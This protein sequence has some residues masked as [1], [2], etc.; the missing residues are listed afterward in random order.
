MIE[1]SNGN[2]FKSDAE[3]L[4]NAVNCMGVMGAGLALQFRETFPENFAAYKKACT[5][6]DLR[7]GEMFVWKSNRSGGPRYIINFPTKNH[8]K[9]K[10]HIEYIELGLVAL[11]DAIRE[12]GIESIAIP[13][14]GCGLGGLDWE[15][16]R[17]LIE[18]SLGAVPDVRAILYGPPGA[19]PN[20]KQEI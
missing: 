2:L 17:P 9:T 4:V 18:Q 6:G 1:F 19:G 8:W 12:Q 10:S 3:A 5:R 16:V 11:V 20:R 7:I 14:L 13:R 15:D